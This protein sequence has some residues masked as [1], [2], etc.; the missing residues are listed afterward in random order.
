VSREV[1]VVDTDTPNEAPDDPHRLARLYARQKCHHPQGFVL[2]FWRGEWHAWTDNAYRPRP[3]VEVRAGLSDVIKDE[4]DRVN[5]AE[6]RDYQW[7]ANEGKLKRGE[8]VPTVRKVTQTLVGN[9]LQALTGLAVLP[10]DTRQPAW[11]DGEVPL[12]ADEVLAAANGLV[13][14]PSYVRR[15][16]HF[17]EATPLDGRLSSASP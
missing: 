16:H 7:R 1:A 12:K 9:V 17:L 3:T 5:L 10:A 13:H 2:R 8:D 15:E 14:L 4:F 11:R 6:M